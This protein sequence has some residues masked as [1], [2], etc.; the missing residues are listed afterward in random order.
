MRFSSVPISKIA[1]LDTRESQRKFDAL[2]PPS[3][4][5]KSDRYDSIVIDL[6]AIYVREGNPRT[7]PFTR[8]ITFSLSFSLSLFHFASSHGN[9]WS[10]ENTNRPSS[11]SEKFGPST[12]YSFHIILFNRPLMCWK[13][14]SAVTSLF[15]IN[16]IYFLFYCKRV[17]FQR[18]LSYLL[19]LSRES[20][21]SESFLFCSL[22]TLTHSF[23]LFFLSLSFSCLRDFFCLRN[24]RSFLFFF[25]MQHIMRLGSTD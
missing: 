17:N 8:P 3:P 13:D 24:F 11:V 2:L 4:Y 10:A 20:S 25:F 6:S 18:F 7:R 14:F 15:H 21:L 22:L 1:I 5:H 23:S 9:I 19:F 12:L 16:R